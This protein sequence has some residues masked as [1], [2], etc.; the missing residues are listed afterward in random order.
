LEEQY[1]MTE[2]VLRAHFNAKAVDAL[3][4][5]LQSGQSP[6]IDPKLF[7]DQLV[8]AGIEADAASLLDAAAEAALVERIP[9]L[10]C[11]ERLCRRI[12][13]ADDIAN[14]HCSHCGAD[15]REAGTDPIEA[16]IYRGST[17]VSHSVPWLIAVHGF[18]TRG[19]WQE[20]FSWR[21]AHRFKYHA[22]VLIY[23][24][25]LVRF[26]VL[27][28][29]RHRVLARSLGQQI[30]KA[31]VQARDNQIEEPPDIVIH[32]FGSQLFRLVLES[33]EFSDLRFGR[34][35]A[36]GSVIRP[37]F[38]WS[39]HIR[40]RRIEAVLDQCGGGDWAVPFA[41]FAIPG[42]GPGGRKGF[43]DP[44]VI[45]VRNAQYGHSTAFFEAELARN[46]AY[47]GTWDRFLREPLAS[48]SDPTQF[49][50]AAWSPAY[51]FIRWLI[52]AIVVL[53]ISV[54]MLAVA[55]L[56]I[57]GVLGAVDRIADFSRLATDFAAG[58][59]SR[60]LSAIGRLLP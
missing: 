50:P 44:A 7:R 60:F 20:E 57:L 36:V 42:T 25:G 29:W 6:E 17:T 9:V 3:I 34:V 45:N 13:D 51:G 32:S 10:R 4:A 31:V 59:Q 22:P 40:H 54:I 15:F 26:G 35:I 49:T 47:G 8:E 5:L 48:F 19:P 23:K 58:V 55:G 30:R 16:V 12:I 18:N 43:T 33:D 1:A 39:S 46:L 14:R 27:F 53:T 28:R 56:I 11:P 41:Q 21:V 52:H 38:D 37:D 24:Y 2:D